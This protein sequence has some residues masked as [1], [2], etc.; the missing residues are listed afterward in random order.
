ML[1]YIPEGLEKCE[2]VEIA[3]I[4]IPESF[5]HPVLRIR[6][7]G[8]RF[9]ITKKEPIAEGDKSEQSEYTISLSEDEYKSLAELKGKRFRKI[10]YYYPLEGRNAEIDVYKDDLEGLAVAEFEFDSKEEKDNF[11]MPEFCLADVSQEEFVGGGFL[12][13]K[14]FSDIKAELDRCGYEE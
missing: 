3:D 6:K 13:G 12:A 2:H 7:R 10:R 5:K 8:N 9:E 14:K 4:F 11:Q 1:K